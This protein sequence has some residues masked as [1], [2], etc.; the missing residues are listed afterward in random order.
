MGGYCMTFSHRYNTSNI[1]ESVQKDNELKKVW[2]ILLEYFCQNA[3]QVKIRYWPGDYKFS[4]NPD[5]VS[6][7]FG[8]ESLSRYSISISR[9]DHCMEELL[10]PIVAETI[11]ILLQEG[12]TNVTNMISPWFHIELISTEGNTVFY[13]GDYGQDI[14]MFLTD[15]DTRQL[16]SLGIIMDD[17]IKLT[18]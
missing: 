14:L 12:N 10:A 2:A 18:E 9:I 16:A 7:T 17:L 11:Q 4:Q 1:E 15:Y 8:V 3:C 6:S 13:S 5:Y